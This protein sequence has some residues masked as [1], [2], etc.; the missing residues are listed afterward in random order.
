MLWSP[1]L[2]SNA[3]SG[4]AL[5]WL[6]KYF[7]HHGFTIFTTNMLVR[8]WLLLLFFSQKKLWSYVIL[9]MFKGCE[10]LFP[11]HSPIGVLHYSSGSKLR[12]CYFVSE[13]FRKFQISS[14]LF[15]FFFMYWMEICMKL[16]WLLCFLKQ[17]TRC[18][19]LLL[20]V[21]NKNAGWM[22]WW[23]LVSCAPAVTGPC[24]FI[25]PH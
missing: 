10:C 8:L 15:Y 18:L 14:T 13:E 23:T 2:K 21:Q 7:I 3:N 4:I 19:V 17:N 20:Q 6:W 11:G 24:L 5:L 1:H 12:P 22:F 25:L 9:T 16:L